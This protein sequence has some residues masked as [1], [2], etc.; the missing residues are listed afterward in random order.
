MENKVKNVLVFNESTQT[1]RQLP[2]NYLIAQFDGK[3]GFVNLI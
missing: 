2:Q 1:I 3:N